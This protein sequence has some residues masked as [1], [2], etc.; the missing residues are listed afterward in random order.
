MP[1]LPPYIIEPIWEQLTAL[2][3][4]REVDHPLGCHRPRIPDRAVFEKLVQ[5][6]VF[7]CAYEKIADEGCSA[8]TLRRRRDEWILAGVVDALREMALEAYDRMIGLELS[9][10]AVDCCITKAPCGGEKAGRSPVDRGKAGIKRSVAVDGRGIP[11]GALT[12]AAN[13][14]DSPLLVPT[15]EAV[16]TPGLLPEGVV[17]HLG[18]Y[19]SKATR[20]RLLERGLVAEISGKGKPAPLSATKRWVVERTNS[21]QNAH[22]KLAWCTERR[23]RVVDFWMALSD[24]VIIVR[25]LV[26][27]GW[28]RY[29]WERR[30]SRRP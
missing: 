28:T 5:V 27:E 15:L 13:R 19:D 6:L 11:L 1:A 22:K 12:A 20:L 9:E 10:V 21:W 2:L 24:A 8:S 4:E 23:G 25:R 18:G 26:R 14:H 29:R 7:G 30:P 3:P 17:V 16:R